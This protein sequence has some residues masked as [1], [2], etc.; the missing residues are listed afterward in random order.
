MRLLKI[1]LMAIL[2]IA[3]LAM[4]LLAIGGSINISL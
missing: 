1:V 2:V 3:L 4:M